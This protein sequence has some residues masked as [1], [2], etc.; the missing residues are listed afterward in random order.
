[1]EDFSSL[2]S[3]TVLLGMIGVLELIVVSEDGE[4]F[5]LFISFGPDSCEETRFVL[6]GDAIFDVSST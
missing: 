4:P 2:L 6:S 1:M 5:T 3:L